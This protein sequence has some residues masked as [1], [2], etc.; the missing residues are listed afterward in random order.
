[1]YEMNS[2]HI[3]KLE[4]VEWNDY[5]FTAIAYNTNGNHGWKAGVQGILKIPKIRKLNRRN[6]S[7]FAQ[8]GFPDG[9]ELS[10]IRYGSYI[11][12]HNANGLPAV[13]Y[14]LEIEQ[15]NSNKEISIFTGVAAVLE[16]SDSFRYYIKNWEKPDIKGIVKKLIEER[17]T[18][19]YRFTL[20][21][22][23]YNNS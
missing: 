16:T 17:E 18:I 4:N 19:S 22:S 2:V 6:D 1:M 7:G 8:N 14:S 10:M 21:N 5:Y 23:L 20:D 3:E 15:G 9:T 11:K 13:I 12:P